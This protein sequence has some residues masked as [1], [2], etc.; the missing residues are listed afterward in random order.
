MTITRKELMDYLLEEQG[1]DEEVVENMPTE[2][3]L[4]L[5]EMYHED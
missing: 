1:Y 5:Y 3:M 4:D 2:E